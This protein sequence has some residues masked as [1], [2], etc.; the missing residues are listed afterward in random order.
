MAIPSENGKQL[1]SRTVIGVAQTGY[2]GNRTPSRKYKV[3]NG[4]TWRGP[5]GLS[6]CRGSISASRPVR[7]RIP[8]PA[9]SDA[10]RTKM[11]TAIVP[12]RECSGFA[13][14][15]SRTELAARAQER[16]ATQRR[17][18]AASRGVELVCLIVAS[19]VAASVLY[20]VY[21]AKTHDLEQEQATTLN[22]NEL[23]GP[24]QLIPFLGMIPAP[25]DQEFIANQIYNLKRHGEEFNNVGAIARLRVTESE[26]AKTRGLV[27]FPKRLSG[28]PVPARH[29]RSVPLLT[30]QEFADLKPHLRVRNTDDYRH[31][32][33][34]WAVLFFAPFYAVHLVWRLR[35]FSCDNLILPIVHAVCGIGL[36]LMIS[37]RDPLR[38]TLMFGDFTQGV[39]AGCAALLVFSIPNYQRQFGR[40]SYLPLL[41]AL[42]LAVALRL[43]G[44]GP[45]ASDA[46]VNLF[47]FQPVEIIR[48]LIVFFLA[49]YF[50][51][52]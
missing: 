12:A 15:V 37:L 46:R 29:E 36:I 47:F 21:A 13:M 5:T 32:I 45:G 34:L 38:D 24:Q 25:S 22:L 48:I 10:V 28:L 44:S 8:Q 23:A 51:Q 7:R 9:P 31:R 17:S 39:I 19:L 30:A 52:N 41:A 42:L 11:R 4:I 3:R 14:K 6:S 20:L 33:F 40:L 43:F 50:A 18:R 26:L 16:S 27:S 2:G 1:C 49:G 35:A